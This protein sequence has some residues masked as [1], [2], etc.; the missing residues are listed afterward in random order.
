MGGNVVNATVK[1]TPPDAVNVEEHARIV[2]ELLKEYATTLAA[3][4]SALLTAK[5]DGPERK[6]WLLDQGELLTKP[7]SRIISRGSGLLEHSSLEP[8]T[9]DELALRM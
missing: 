2:S 1:A 6:A 7:L 5:E 4:N 8:L 3:L 9:E